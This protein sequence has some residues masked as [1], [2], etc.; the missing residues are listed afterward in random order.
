MC[1]SRRD[2]R[3]EHIDT[4]S[5]KKYSNELWREHL[6]AVYSRYTNL[7]AIITVVA[8]AHQHTRKPVFRS[9][10]WDVIRLAQAMFWQPPS[11]RNRKLC[12][13]LSF[14]KE[15]KECREGRNDIM[16]VM[17]GG[18]FLEILI[19]SLI[20]PIPSRL[21]KIS[22][23]TAYR[24]NVGTQFPGTTRIKACNNAFPASLSCGRLQAIDLR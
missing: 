14:K 16:A 23:A 3:S 7:Y 11:I 12:W 20:L 6:P 21:S 9:A 5:L 13:P 1:A 8:P 15:S 4:R 24:T 17:L 22:Y 2:P 10:D 19:V 18:S